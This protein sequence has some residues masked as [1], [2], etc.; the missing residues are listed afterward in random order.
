MSNLMII[1]IGGVVPACLWGV[2]AI[3]QKQSAAHGMHPGLYLAL[4]GVITAGVGVAGALAS[5]EFEWVKLGSMHA[6]LAGVTYAL[7]AGLISFALWR[8]GAPISKLAPILSCGVLVTVALGALV[9]GEAAKFNFIQ[10]T[11]GTLL[12]VGGAILVTNA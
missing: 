2:S 10:L 3:F 4:F 9:L 1:L 7:G 11:I 6:A 12:I 8:Y 5:R